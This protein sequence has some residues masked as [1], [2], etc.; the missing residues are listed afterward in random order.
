MNLYHQ[1][2]LYK[3]NS[4]RLHCVADIVAFPES[5]KEL[6]D[7]VLANK[8]ELLIL[9]AGSNIIL[10]K[11]LHR[12]VV[13]MRDFS[14]SIKIQDNIVCCAA[15]VRIQKLIRA[16]QEQ[17]LGGIEYLFS[18]PCTVGRCRSRCA[19]HQHQW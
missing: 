5:E 11:T 1:F 9:G 10:P 8:D 14:D 2:D 7:F 13:V 17:S 12:T 19:D 4:M 16:I 3:Y 15:S 6:I 18:V